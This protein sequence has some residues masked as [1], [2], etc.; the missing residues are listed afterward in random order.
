MIVGLVGSWQSPSSRRFEWLA[1]AL[2]NLGH[3]TVRASGLDQAREACRG[4]D[5]AIFESNDAGLSPA[6]WDAL[7]ADKRSPWV[8][9][10]FQLTGEPWAAA[11]QGVIERMDLVLVRERDRLAEYQSQGIKAQWIEQ[12][13]PADV[14]QA[15]H[16]EAP[17]WDVLVLANRDTDDLRDLK[18][19]LDEGFAIGWCNFAGGSHPP[20]GVERL[21]NVTLSEFPDLA[22]RA[23]V[24][25]GI[26]PRPPVDGYVSDSDLLALGAGA[27]LVRPYREGLPNVS[28]FSYKS[29]ERLMGLMNEL[30]QSVATRRSTGE[31]ARRQVLASHTFEHRAEQV[32]AMLGL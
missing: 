29:Q 18:L 27:C 21:G 10:W 2:A 1:K 15:E 14:G 16:N 22:S 28:F 24:V 23:C 9:W 5:L 7:A 30:R 6:E 11:T 4:C 32:L 26:D 8:Q 19:L 20:H 3:R 13:C 17:D 31:R 25:L 12:A